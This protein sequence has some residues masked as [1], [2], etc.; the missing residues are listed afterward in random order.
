MVFQRKFEVKPVPNAAKSWEIGNTN[1][2][3]R[4]LMKVYLKRD[5][6]ETHLILILFLK[7][8]WKYLKFRCWLISLLDNM[9]Y[10]NELRRW[11]WFYFIDHLR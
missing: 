6:M 3:S 1:G 10:L 9:F 5:N 8:K 11:Y 7:T 4:P 2:K